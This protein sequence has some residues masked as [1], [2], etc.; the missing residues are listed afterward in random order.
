ML[1]IY[2]KQKKLGD[3]ITSPVGFPTLPIW[4]ALSSKSHSFVFLMFVNWQALLAKLT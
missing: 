4:Q 3:R 1:A 2:D